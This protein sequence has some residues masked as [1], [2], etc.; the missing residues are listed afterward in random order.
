MDV[1]NDDIHD[2]TNINM[3]EIDVEKIIKEWQM[4]VPFINREMKHPCT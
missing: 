1:K 2:T 4:Y 3:D